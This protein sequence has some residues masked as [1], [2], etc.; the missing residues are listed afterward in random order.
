MNAMIEMD[1]TTAPTSIFKAR[2]AGG[3]DERGVH[4][5]TLYNYPVADGGAFAAVKTDFHD[6]VAKAPDGSD[7]PDADEQWM[8]LPPGTSVTLRRGTGNQISQ[9]QVKGVSDSTVIGFGITED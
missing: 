7:A 4:A 9:V 3:Y 8:P 6:A 5:I 1:I 2:N